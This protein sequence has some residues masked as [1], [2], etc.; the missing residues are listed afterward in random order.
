MVIVYANSCHVRKNEGSNGN[1]FSI[2][3]L[4]KHGLKH[5]LWGFWPFQ[6]IEVVKA[7]FVPF[8]H[9]AAEVVYRD[10]WMYM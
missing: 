3:M 9:G 4:L 5:Q 6:S 8:I 2:S 10:L 7:T 1:E